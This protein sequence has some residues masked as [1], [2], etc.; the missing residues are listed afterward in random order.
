MPEDKS[1]IVKMAFLY[2]QGGEWYKAI[3]EYKKLLALDPED[4][5]V[6]NM[7]GDAYAKKKDDADA[8]KSY[9]RSKELY[10]KQG[11]AQ[12]IASIEKKIAKLSTEGM[13]LKQRQFFQSV[14][15]TQEADALASEGRLD[16]A[17]AYYLQLI[18]AEPI[19][20]SY[21]EKLA[22]LFLEN[23]MVA[24]AAAQLKAIADIHLSEGRLEEAQACGGKVS[25]IDPD[26]LD[27][28][29]LLA[30][31]ASRKGDR[32][33]EAE[34]SGK[35]ARMAFDA[36]MN[37]EALSALETAARAGRADLKPLKARVL[38][39]LKRP[40]EA[41]AALEDLLRENPGD[42]SLMEQLL[43]LCE[44]TKDWP[45]AHAHIT[46]LLSKRPQDPKLQPRLARILL[47]VGRR[48][49]ALQV[50]LSL[51]Q[52]ALAENRPEAGLS[53]LDSALALEPDHLEALK[54]KAEAQLKL[55]RK[56]E[57]I[58]AY[59][60]LQAALTAKKMAEEAKKVGLILT[61]LA[62]LK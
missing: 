56:A 36:G 9:L 26:G 37:E 31:L 11:Q 15:K 18:A 32:A 34:H 30:A 21:R 50:Y 52:S 7:M 6:H 12:K 55:G 5:H 39:A 23:A 2:F 10:G 35:L 57:T 43:S 14:T 41:K 45:S 19:N 17:V 8:L 25:L 16:E 48:P 13:D 3:E 27:T 42:E 59:R 49:E 47:Q 46:A 29:R 44:E 60:K 1:M 53:Y 24:E 40:G 62:G 33:G 4:A 58:E 38:A 22:N 51:A 28:H 61:R 20:F 54:K